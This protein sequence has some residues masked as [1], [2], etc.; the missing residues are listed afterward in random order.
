MKRVIYAAYGSNLL[1]ERFE[2]YIYGRRFR[3][4]RY[5]GSRDKTP[6]VD[7]GWIIVP[8]FVYFAKNSRKWGGGGVAFLS[9]EPIEDC[10]L[11]SV[12]R[13]WEVS[14]MQFEDIW[15]QENSAKTLEEAK[16]G[17]YGRIITLGE[18]DGLEIKTFTGDWLDE[19]NPP[20]A[21]YLEI[22]KEGLLETTR[23]SRKEIETYWRSRLAFC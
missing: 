17:W 5:E 13:L 18:I 6:P 7:R 10:S 4:V 14:E 8:R 15:K 21:K 9:S 3:G 11:W 2:A 16:N 23:W 19:K 20:S 12:V 1:K 22:V